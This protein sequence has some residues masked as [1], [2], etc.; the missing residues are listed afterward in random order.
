MLR[1]LDLGNGVCISDKEEQIQHLYFLVE[2]VPLVRPLVNCFTKSL[3]LPT[4]L[5]FEKVLG[6]LFSACVNVSCINNK[7]ICSL[8]CL[9]DLTMNNS[10]VYTLDPCGGHLSLC[11]FGTF[12]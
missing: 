7:C 10:V 9:F 12:S 6:L 8:P 1:E 2:K 5:W 3:V 4:K 11:F